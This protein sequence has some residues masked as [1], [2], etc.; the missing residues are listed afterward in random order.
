MSLGKRKLTDQ[1][2]LY[3]G[4]IFS[5]YPQ[6]KEVEV[7]FVWMALKKIDKEIRDIVAD[8]TRDPERQLWL[9]QRFSPLSTCDPSAWQYAGHNLADAISLDFTHTTRLAELVG[10]AFARKAV[11][12]KAELYRGGV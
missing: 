4:Y 7:G 9:A 2:E 11:E 12:W 6:V 8:A 1:L 3:A 10:A 5:E